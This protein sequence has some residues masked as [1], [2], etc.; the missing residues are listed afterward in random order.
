MTH[1]HQSFSVQFTYSVFFTEH[2]FAPANP[3][4]TD[5]VSQQVTNG[6]TRKV[7]FVLDSGVDLDSPAFITVDR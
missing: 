7:L 6:T 1:L 4:L 2:L 3:L 5:F